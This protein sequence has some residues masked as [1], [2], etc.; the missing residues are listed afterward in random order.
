MNIPI[1]ALLGVVISLQAWQLLSII[2][3]KT[4]HAAISQAVK[5]IQENCKRKVCK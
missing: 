5:D 3:L 2:S 4:S 1:E